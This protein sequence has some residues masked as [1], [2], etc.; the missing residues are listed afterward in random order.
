LYTFGSARSLHIIGSARK[1]DWSGI[2]LII[3]H[4]YITQFIEEIHDKIHDVQG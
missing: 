3:I 4:A 1:T 2:C